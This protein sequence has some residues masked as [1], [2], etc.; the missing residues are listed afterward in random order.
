[1]RTIFVKET[2]SNISLS[3]YILNTF[4]NLSKG[5]LFK[6]LRNKDIKVNEKRV[7]KDILVGVNDKIDIYIKDNILYNIPKIIQYIYQDENVAIVFKP[8]GL[9]SNNEYGKI[10]EPTLEDIVK[11]DNQN[12]ILCHRLDRNT[13]GLLMFAKSKK[14]CNSISQAFRDNLIEKEYIA[15]V[16]N[17]K[18]NEN[19]KVLKQYISIDKKNGIS[20]IY[21]ENNTLYNS[22]IK[23]ITTSYKVLYSNKEKNYAILKVKIH[24]GKTHQIRAVLAS[25]GH[26]IIGDSKYGKNEINKKF[27]RYRQLLFA[28][29][30]NFNFKEDAYLYYLN[31]KNILLEDK[32]YTNYIGDIYEKI[33]ES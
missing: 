1:M 7:N 17:Y 10:N 27:K 22:N 29:K 26:P 19:E 3:S 13:C 18:F 20:K 28:V 14:I 6:A 21:N 32:F 2:N 11:N 23:A 31:K 5:A 9:L 15:Y 25:I 8:Q 16:A 33:R 30:F 12:L 4:P 24:N